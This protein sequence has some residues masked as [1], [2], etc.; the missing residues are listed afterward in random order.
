MLYETEIVYLL[1]TPS[2][3]AT[4]TLQ[5]GSQ[6]NI[7]VTKNIETKSPR[8]PRRNAKNKNDILTELENRDIIGVNDA[9]KLQ[10]Y[11]ATTGEIYAQEKRTR[12]K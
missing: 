10:R 7:Y 2:P 11:N 3:V 1:T 5:T 12:K 4:P 8:T 6:C 9:E